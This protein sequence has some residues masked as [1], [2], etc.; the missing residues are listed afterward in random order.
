MRFLHQYN[1]M[2]PIMDGTKGAPLP[3]EVST[4]WFGFVKEY[5][6]KAGISEVIHTGSFRRGKKITGDLDVAFVDSSANGKSFFPG[7][8]EDLEGRLGEK[9]KK[10]KLGD[11]QYSGKTEKTQH[12]LDFNMGKPQNRGALLLFTTGSGDFNKA[13][14]FRAKGMG[15][16]LS[17]YGLRWR[18]TDEVIVSGKTEHELF[19]V[20]GLAFVEPAQRTTG[21]GQI[22]GLVIYIPSK[23]NRLIEYKMVIG[24]SLTCACLGFVYKG[25]CSHLEDA[26]T[27]IAS[28]K[29]QLF[30][31]K[32]IDRITINSKEDW[33]RTFYVL[34]KKDKKFYE[35]VFDLKSQAFWEAG[36]KQMF[37]Q[38]RFSPQV[39]LLIKIWI[40]GGQR[41]FVVRPQNV[42]VVLRNGKVTQF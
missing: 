23:K 10:I 14:R 31:K 28:G 6:L 30:L 42:D 4:K 24:E 8:I 33:E 32:S 29:T 5:S 1:K 18:D 35:I 26:K 22:K 27:I 2:C 38:G 36:E 39:S 21:V 11:T 40:E 9:I 15:M 7:L 12:T 19:K 20:L 16:K 13:T 3:L 25:K 37:A 41:G 17:Q 34:N